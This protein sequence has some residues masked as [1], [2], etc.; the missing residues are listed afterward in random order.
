M[1][2]EDTAFVGSIPAV[3]EQLLVPMVFAEPAQHLATA[4]VATD[5]KDILETA[6]GTGVLT[7][8]LVER[9][10]ATITATDLNDPMLQ[11]ASRLC[12]SDRVHWKVA[13]ALDLAFPDGSFD[14]VACQFGVMFFP[15]RPRGYAEALRVLRPGGTFFFSAWNRIEANPAWQAIADTLIA[16]APEEPLDLFPRVPFGYY[17]PAV[18]RADLEKAGY[19][20]IEVTTMGAV[21]H[22]TV[23]EAARAICQ[24][25]TMKAAIE[26]HSSMTVDRATEMAGRA[27]RDEFGEGPID[28]PIS[29]LQVS[30]RATS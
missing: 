4:I 23:D 1:A 24:G 13:D 27:L 17:D 21:S 18:I 25:T 2:A 12:D 14:V 29:W 10:D 3:Y 5:P 7:R 16:T 11:E 6:A 30:A 26:A 20:D 8:A 9:S 19:D 15:D 28:A 22:S